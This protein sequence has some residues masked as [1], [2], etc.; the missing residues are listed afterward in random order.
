MS[1]TERPLYLPW[2]A[3]CDRVNEYLFT[4]STPAG[5]RERV[6]AHAIAMPPDVSIAMLRQSWSYDPLPALREIK[7]PIRAVSADKFPTNLEV[8]RRHMPGYE[9]SIITGS[10]HYPMLE[11]PARFD[12]ALDAAVGRVLAG[13]ADAS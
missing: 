13:K 12:P 3:R 7:A 1:R 9:A 6:L 5:V 11:A 8:N 4:P 2:S 10:G